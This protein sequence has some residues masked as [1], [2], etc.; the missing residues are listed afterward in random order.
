[1]YVPGV[2]SAW[3]MGLWGTPAGSRNGLIWGWART[4]VGRALS[5]YPELGLGGA[6]GLS[7]LPRKK[8]A[9]TPI[10]YTICWWGMQE[11]EQGH[12]RC[13]GDLSHSPCPLRASGNEP[14]LWSDTGCDIHSLFYRL[15]VRSHPNAT[16]EFLGLISSWY[17]LYSWWNL[18]M[19]ICLNSFW[20]QQNLTQFIVYDTINASKY[21]RN[22]FQLVMIRHIGHRCAAYTY[23]HVIWPPVDCNSIWEICLRTPRH[24]VHDRRYIREFTPEHHTPPGGT[25]SKITWNICNQAFDKLHFTCYCQV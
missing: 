18:K 8:C 7:G 16:W 1:M 12:I 22:Y 19:N 6:V 20:E 24:Y 10:V 2:L 11:A 4:L 15:W 14:A 3:Y 21:E 25:M 13:Q 9:R 23:H 5:C 17:L